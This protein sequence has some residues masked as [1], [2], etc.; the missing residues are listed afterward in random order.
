M[1]G[2]DGGQRNSSPPTD[3]GVR[4]VPQLDLQ[5]IRIR[6]MLPS[7]Q[8]IVEQIT[9]EAFKGVSIDQAIEQRFQ[10]I[11]PLSWQA[12]K[13]SAISHEVRE[14]AASSFVAELDQ[15]VVGYITTTVSQATCTGRIAN[16]GVAQGYRGRGLGTRLI[17]QA[18]A[19]FRHRG[20]RLARIE[21]LAQN[22]VGDYLYRKLGFQEVTRQIHFAMPLGRT[23]TAPPDD[24]FGDRD[25]DPEGTT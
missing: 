24:T 17:E 20:L 21:T 5:R 10:L 22:A 9:V 23:P 15:Q 25:H 11:R 6:R 13:G 12:I 14:H 7:D 1:N 3:S 8:S 18:L 19:D 4:D 16:V 2:A